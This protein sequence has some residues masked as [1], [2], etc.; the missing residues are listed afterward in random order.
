[1]QTAQLNI[2]QRSRYPFYCFILTHMQKLYTSTLVHYIG[3]F[4][5]R[6]FIKCAVFGQSGFELAYH[7]DLGLLQT[8]LDSFSVCRVNDRLATNCTKRINFY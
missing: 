3:M 6:L 8:A 4:S 1:M 5:E 2:H 7:K